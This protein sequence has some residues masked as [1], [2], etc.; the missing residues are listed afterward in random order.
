MPEIDDIAWLGGWEG[1]RVCG[2]E[3]VMG[4]SPEIWITLEVT[5]MGDPICEGCSGQASGVHELT[6]R[7]IRDLPILDA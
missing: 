4:S 2:V 3:R 7:R 1:Y 6:V 5:P